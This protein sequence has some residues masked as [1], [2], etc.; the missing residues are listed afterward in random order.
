MTT[1]ATLLD[2]HSLAVECYGNWGSEA[3]QTFSR[4]AS[5]LSFSLPDPK[6]KIFMDLYGKLNTTLVRCNSR[7]LLVR[8]IVMSYDTIYMLLCLVACYV[9]YNYNNMR[10]FP[11]KG[12]NACFFKISKFG[13]SRS[14]KCPLH[15][16]SYAL[17]IE[18]SVTEL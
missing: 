18:L 16:A 15:T 4:L 11:R 5:C 1:N 9:Y 8:S 14:L 12:P 17:R 7:A 2:L 10:S 6:S 3:R 13:Y